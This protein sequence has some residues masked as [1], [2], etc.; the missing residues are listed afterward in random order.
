MPCNPS[1]YTVEPPDVDEP[2][3]PGFGQPFSPPDNLSNLSNPS[4]FPESLAELLEKLT[5]FLPSG[6]Y[7]PNLSPNVDKKLV[8][9]IVKLL[10]LLTPF[11]AVYKFILPILNMILCIIE[12]LCALS[13][14]FKLI[15]AIRRLFRRCIPDF[16][17]LFPIFAMILLIISL[18]LLILALIEYIISEIARIINQ[19]IKNINLLAR[20]IKRKDQRS[21]LTATR[22]IAS[23][24]C[25]LKN[26]FAILQIVAIIIQIIKDLLKLFFRVP[27]C[28]DS[29]TSDDG[30]CT[31]EVCPAFIKNGN[32]TRT[33]GRFQYLSAISEDLSGSGLPASFA[34]LFSSSGSLR[35]ESWQFYD[36]TLANQYAF[37]NITSAYD[38]DP[39]LGFTFFPEGKTYDG[40]S[41][42]NKVPYTLDMKIFYQPSVFGI[43]DPLGNRFVLIKDCVVTKTPD[44]QLK[45]WS[46]AN[47][48]PSNGVLQLAGGKVT[49]IDG[50]TPVLINGT[51]ASLTTL[52]HLNAVVSD[53]LVNNAVAF[54]SIEYTFKINHEVLFGETLI[55][56]GCVPDVAFDRIFANS[57]AGAG[58]AEGAVKLG[59]IPIPDPNDTL[60]QLTKLINDYSQSITI[61]SSNQF[62]ANATA[63]LNSLGNQLTAVLPDFV[64]L[65]FSSSNSTF[66]L[67]PSVQFTTKPIVVT[68]IL[69]DVNGNNICPTLPASAS[70]TIAA[71][72]V[73]EITF[74]NITDFSYDGSALFTAK[75]TSE[76]AGV[77]TIKLMYN[78]VFFNTVTVPTD[79]AQT[80]TTTIQELKYQFVATPVG[81]VGGAGPGTVPGGTVLGDTDGQPRRDEGDVSRQKGD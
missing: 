13:N 54:S 27:P 3:N 39:S 78:N 26:I 31:P 50:K 9:G 22:K 79:L 45:D 48:E 5:V 29:D 61:E 68:A 63:V 7:K 65:G 35:Q 23:L 6:S 76:E 81:N 49:E 71:K 55:S 41:N 70:T 62:Q 8:D 67:S 59:Q 73:P 40:S 44:L 53:R 19:I 60:T 43:N 66:S 14:P 74:G 36:D 15:R 17:A 32:F 16:L 37:Y 80:P 38:V 11:L 75:I 4:G 24:L 42:V 21:A 77:G 30:C 25:F 57:T 56:L 72:L 52:I 1:D 64:D 2:F 18:I 12:V 51:Q 34:S 28:D 47:V 33:T 46:N 69:N 58:M 20:I 10:D